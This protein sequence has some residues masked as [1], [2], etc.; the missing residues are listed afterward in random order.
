VT[1]PRATDENTEQIRAQFSNKAATVY[2]A[3][4]DLGEASHTAIAKRAGVSRPTVQR[5][6]ERLREGGWI[7]WETGQHTNRYKAASALNGLRSNASNA[8]SGRLCGQRPDLPSELGF[9][10]VGHFSGESGLSGVELLDLGPGSL[11]TNQQAP[12]PRPR[13]LLGDADRVVEV[14]VD[15]LKRRDPDKTI[16][17]KRIARFHACAANMLMF[18]RC[19]PGQLVGIVAWVFE[20]HHGTLPFQPYHQFPGC[21]YPVAVERRITRLAQVDRDFEKILEAMR[22]ETLGSLRP[23]ST[24]RGAEGPG[25]TYRGAD[26]PSRRR[27]LECV[28]RLHTNTET[29][30]PVV[31]A[32]SCPT[33]RR[34]PRP[35]TRPDEDSPER[36]AMW[37]QLARRC[38]EELVAAQAAR[39][40]APEGSLRA[41]LEQEE[42]NGQPIGPPEGVIP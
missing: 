21:R 4:I 18:R 19:T 38:R 20:V 12:A 3:A 1:I 33:S 16:S 41:R 8:W 42:R 14:F 25:I 26:G 5:Y 34:S 10:A 27:G 29:P 39:G 40:P 7:A 11:T 17:A 2:A 13:G 28:K 31:P 15:H 32:A 9:D 30:A 22:I 23:G 6:L 37:A 36:M 24:G 35:N